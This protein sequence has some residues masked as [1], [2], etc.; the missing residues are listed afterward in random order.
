M[1]DSIGGTTTGGLTEALGSGGDDLGR[2]AFLKLLTAQLQYQDPL[3]PVEN[4]QFIAE[5]AQ[6][7]GLEQSVGINDR[8]DMLMTQTRGL[9]NTE[10]VSLVGKQ[11]TVK[12]S[13]VSVDGTGVGTPVAFTLDADT[14]TTQVSI[15]DQTGNVVRTIDI[16]ARNDGLVQVT[17]DGRSDAG[18]VQPA[19]AYSVSVNARGPGDVPVG[20]SQEAT[21]LVEAVS[22]DQGF[23]LL[24]LDSGISV[25]VSDL[26]RVE[27]S[28]V[29]P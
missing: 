25:P 1:I 18:V 9:A 24:H 26:L 11:A 12:G 17:W 28:Q 22:F 6:F 13:I 29:G 15:R 14:E 8:L 7:S 16:G 27:T 5:L 19:G 21:G 4:H 10:V 23:P 20:V 2:D 3:K